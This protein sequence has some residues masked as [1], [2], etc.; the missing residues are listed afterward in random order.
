MPG[1]AS[2][3]LHAMR[4]AGLEPNVSIKLTQFG[5]DLSESPARRMWLRW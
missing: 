5:L 4:D 1:H 3:M 2:A